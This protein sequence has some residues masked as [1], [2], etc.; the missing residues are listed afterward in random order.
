MMAEVLAACLSDEIRNTTIFYVTSKIMSSVRDY[1]TKSATM[2]HLPHLEE[3]YTL[4]MPLSSIL[5]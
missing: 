1:H 4:P 5:K 2:L 3:T